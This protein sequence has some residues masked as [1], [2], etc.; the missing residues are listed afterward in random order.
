MRQPKQ[1]LL[2]SIVQL[3]RA[4]LSLTFI[5]SGIVKIID[6]K[7]FSYKLHDYFTAM[8]IAD[9]LPTFSHLL[10]AAALAMIEFTIGVYLLFG[11][12]RRLTASLALLMMLLMTPL[13]LWVWLWEPVKDCGCFGDA[14]TLSGNATFFKNL[15]LLLCS[16]VVARFPLY[17]TRIISEKAQWIIS[18]YAWIY[19]VAL[20][21]YCIYTEP[22]IDFRPYHVGADILKGMQIPAE[23]EEV[24][25]EHTFLMEK[26]GE[27]RE[28]TLE[29]YPDSTWTFV[30][31]NTRV[32]GPA[33]QLPD[34]HDLSLC[35]PETGEDITETLL[36]D[37]G[38][39]FLIIAP[40]LKDADDSVMDHLA[41]ISDYCTD[42]GYPIWCLTASDETDRSEW[43]DITGADYPYLLVDETP[44]KTMMRSNPGLMLLHGAVIVNKFSTNQLP[45]ES[46]LTDYIE[47]LPISKPNDKS[48]SDSIIDLLLWFILPLMFITLLD[49]SIAVAKHYYKHYTITKKTKL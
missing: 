25:F 19:G 14:V 43:T 11:I 44:L 23:S 47:N 48:L 6:P 12:R 26:N 33:D 2:W 42:Y 17:Q 27:Q 30:S 46:D 32:S 41:E 37:D 9:I 16:I 24:K 7:G 1:I 31:R 15:V 13:T 4:L 18:Q 29:D 8:G 40:H 45:S 22:I 28:F 35:L 38:W 49:R 39:K 10:I 3:S 20:T 5:F 36:M 21:L 34:I